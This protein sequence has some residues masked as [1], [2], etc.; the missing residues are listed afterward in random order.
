MSTYHPKTK[1]FSVL[2]SS[3]PQRERAGLPYVVAATVASHVVILSAAIWATDFRLPN[4]VLDRTPNDVMTESISDIILVSPTKTGPAFKAT[5]KGPTKLAGFSLPEPPN[6]VVPDVAGE[7]QGAL[8][9]A[10]ADPPEFAL[11]FAVPGKQ[12]RDS[13]AVG[14]D[15]ITDLESGPRITAYTRAPSL[16]NENEIQQFISRRFPEALRRQGGDARGIVWLLIDTRGQV[17]KTV[18]RDT[19]GR[20]DVDSVVVAAGQIMRFRPA[21]QAGRPVPVWVQQPIRLHVEDIV[22]H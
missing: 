9:R 4:G 10:E 19:S 15:D 7:I 20:A 8:S 14:G 6:L 12:Q 11:D 17:L 2:I 3:H 21:E 13:A 16:R 18:L 22:G 5:H 1:L